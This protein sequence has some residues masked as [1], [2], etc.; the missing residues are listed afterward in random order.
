M[1]II[2]KYALAASLLALAACSGNGQGAANGASAE[3][4]RPAPT[5]SQNQSSP[6]ESQPAAEAG[7]TAADKTQPTET[8]KESSV[9]ELQ[10]HIPSGSKLLDSKTGD[11]NGDGRPD[12]LLVL[13]HGKGDEKLGEGTPRT[14]VVLVRDAAG[15]LQA[16]AQNNKLVPCASCGGVSGDPYGYVR[17]EDGRF[18]VA[19]GGGSRER[20][21]D[22]YTFAYAS[23]DWF[24]DKVMRSVT[25]TETDDAKQKE[26][27]AKELGK[28]RFEDFDPSQLEQVTL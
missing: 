15:T 12:A 18:T 9:N 4:G 26:F 23:D 20:W 5:A 11:L 10:A 17:I 2:G 8:S 24:V 22:D 1:Q 14:I 13:D 7:P 3:G 25:D 27:T 6:Q 28:V 21:S 16:V 19:V